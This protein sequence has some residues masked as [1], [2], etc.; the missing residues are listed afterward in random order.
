MCNNR[1]TDGYIRTFRNTR[2]DEGNF[3]YKDVISLMFLK[4]IKENRKV[5][6]TF[7]LR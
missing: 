2:N 5:H 3:K 1:I 4:K 7:F 6:L